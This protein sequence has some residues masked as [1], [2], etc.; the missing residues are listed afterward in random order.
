MI[1][2]IERHDVVNSLLLAGV[3]LLFGYGIISG[4]G[5]LRATADEGLVDAVKR[6]TTTTAPDG[7][8]LPT[9]TT[10]ADG[11]R[12]ASGI[13]LRVANAT[14]TG[15][16]AQAAT[17]KLSADGY[18]MLPPKTAGSLHEQTEV[19]YVDGFEGEAS[20]LATKLELSPDNVAL[21]PAQPDFDVDEAHLVLVLG[22]D[23]TQT[24]SG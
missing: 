9:T 23:W 22:A 21:V 12:P 16:I 2:Q 6:T 11:L 19:W 5:M 18:S 4:V 1:D 10:I 7:T 20:R 17:D 13:I 14:S 3:L 24:G 8:T 15:G